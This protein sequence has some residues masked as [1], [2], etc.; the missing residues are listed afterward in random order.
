MLVLLML[1]WRSHGKQQK[2][3]GGSRHKHDAAKAPKPAADADGLTA[4]QR[5]KVV[6]KAIIS[7]SSE[8]DSD[9]RFVTTTS[10][11]VDVKGL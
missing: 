10:L 8:S 4:K 7:S 6:S 2:E 3:K 11:L 1:V 9:D 5:K